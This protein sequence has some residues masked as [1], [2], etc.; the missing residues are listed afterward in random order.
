MQKST[1][2]TLTKE[3]AEVP[4]PYC[5]YRSHQFVAPLL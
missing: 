5:G 3:H 1:V 4:A 2:M